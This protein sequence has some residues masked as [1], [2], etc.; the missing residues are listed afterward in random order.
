MAESPGERLENIHNLL[1]S[2][3]G[4]IAVTLEKRKLSRSGLEATLDVAKEA[5]TEIEE[6]IET[7]PK[8]EGE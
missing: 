1:S 7:L 6:L 4:D 2:A 5:V 3:S 8:K